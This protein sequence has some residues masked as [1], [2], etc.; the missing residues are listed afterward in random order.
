M[1]DGDMF[2]YGPAGNELLKTLRRSFKKHQEEGHKA[3]MLFLMS[4]HANENVAH[5][6]LQDN[7][8]DAVEIA[9]HAMDAAADVLARIVGF[10]KHLHDAGS[11]NA[12]IMDELWDFTRFRAHENVM[13]ILSII[14][15]PEEELS[16]DVLA[17]KQTLRQALNRMDKDGLAGDGEN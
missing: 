15:Y 7:P 11:K 1:S 17:V 12:G 5:I 6:L 13:R 3:A 4:S 10:R 9:L 14:A 2:D 16:P 8:G